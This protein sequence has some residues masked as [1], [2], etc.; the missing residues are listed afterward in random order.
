[1]GCVVVS[2]VEDADC[3]WVG[4]W[5]G[6]EEADEADFVVDFEVG[7]RG[8]C[9]RFEVFGVIEGRVLSS[10]LAFEVLV[11]GVLAP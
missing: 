7:A 6:V 4:G 3:G 9:V 8:H 2:A 11:G 10:G 1:M 5:E